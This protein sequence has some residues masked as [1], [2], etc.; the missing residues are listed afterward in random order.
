MIS[1]KKLKF[2]KVKWK[3]SK[4]YENILFVFEIVLKEIFVIL[5]KIKGRFKI[6]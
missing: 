5:D 2:I 6:I 1:I 4:I 3:I